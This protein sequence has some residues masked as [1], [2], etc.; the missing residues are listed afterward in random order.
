MA[1]R[2]SLEEYQRVGM[3]GLDPTE[4]LRAIDL[5]LKRGVSKAVI[6]DTRWERFVS[7]MSAR[8]ARC[9]FNSVL[10]DKDQI[11][12][13]QKALSKEPWLTELRILDQKLQ[14][15]ELK[16][17]IRKELSEVLKSQEERIPSDRNLFRLGLDSIT[18]VELSMRIKKGTGIVAGKWLSGEPTIDSVAKALLDHW[19]AETSANPTSVGAEIARPLVTGPWTKE[20]IAL[21]SIEEKKRKMLDWLARDLER[22]FGKPTSG[23]ALE[24]RMSDLGLD[25]LGSVDFA[26]H[27]RKQLGLSSPPRLMQYPTIGDWILSILNQPNWKRTEEAPPSG[28]TADQGA[29]ILLF[30]PSLHADVMDFCAQGWQDRVPEIQQKR[31]DWMFVGSATR[32]QTTPKVWLARDQNKIVGQM[33]VQFTGLKLAKEEIRSG[34]LVETMVLD[35]YR[36][37]GLGAQILLQAEE[38]MP[39]AL[40][41][42]Q[43]PEVRKILD[44]LGWKQICPLNIHVFMTNPQS[45]LKGK[46]PM[47]LD[48][49]AAAY[50]SLHRARRNALQT[51]RDSRIEFRRIERFDR[52]HDALWNE[53][54][55]SVSCLAV[56][57]SSFLNWKYFDQPAMSYDCWEIILSD[58]ILGV[59]IT[60]TENATR[61]YPYSRLHWIDLICPMD[62]RTINTMIQGCIKKSEEL[63]VDAISVHLTHKLIE[64]GLIENGFLN[65]PPTRYLFASRGLLEAHPNL[66]ELDWLV[67]KGDSDIDRPNWGDQKKPS[68]GLENPPR[69]EEIKTD[70][71]KN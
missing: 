32:L 51:S 40:S 54:R 62:P 3:Q 29:E 50:F 44:S 1:D 43:T 41:L 2:A 69:Q 26:T 28:Q 53:M 15:T 8:R 66:C 39:Q 12:I 31:W 67:T 55:K 47:G 17:L 57:D 24:T 61:E 7:V 56:R 63:K 48:R 45:I 46:F 71:N 30:E 33:G 11:R 65:R 14:E 9:V 21:S 19:R 37:Q 64:Q 49:L 60:R 58:R 35:R 23:L 36:S 25:S 5:V 38:Q 22:L 42:G 16:R 52:S 34:W 68:E 6:T 4:T 13:P 59:V 18:A 70:R 10:L 27:L 20:L